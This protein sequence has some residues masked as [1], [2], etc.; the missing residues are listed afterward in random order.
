MRFRTQYDPVNPPAVKSVR[1]C[2]IS[3]THSQHHNIPGGIPQCDILIHA[4][5]ITSEGE[6]EKLLRF[7]EW[8]SQIPLPK[9]RKICIAGNHDITFAR[10]PELAQGHIQQW[11]YLEDSSTEVFGL[12]IY[13][14]PW[15]PSFY[16]EHWAF[17]VDR[18]PLARRQWERIPEDTDILI[19]HGPPFGY[20]DKI[21]N[22]H[23]GCEDLADR[24]YAVRPRLTVC[25]HIHENHGTFAAP[26]GTVVNACTMT[27]GYKPKQAP[28]IIDVPIVETV[29]I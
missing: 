5:D 25:G 12:K 6:L 28:I 7:D 2:C 10:D 8:G 4:G 29:T 15:S 14:T 21:D 18:G 24:L 23:V 13:G 22:I 9:E 20:G 11:T 3:D 17:N 16:P 26:W 1:I 27:G 19:V